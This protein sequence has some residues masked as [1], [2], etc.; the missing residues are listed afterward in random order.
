M[1]VGDKVKAT[2]AD[3]LILS[4]VYTEDN[5]GYVILVDEEGHQIVCDPYHVI[6]EVI[7]EAR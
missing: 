7:D 5:R 4:G 6:F 2:W 3:G 1:K